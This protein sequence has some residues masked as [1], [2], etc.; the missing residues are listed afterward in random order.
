MRWSQSKWDEYIAN[1]KCFST[2]I[3]YLSGCLILRNT[4]FTWKTINQVFAL[5]KQPNRMLYYT[6]HSIHRNTQKRTTYWMPK[7]LNISVNSKISFIY[8]LQNVDLSFAKVLFH[9][10]FNSSPPLPSLNRLFFSFILTSF[11]QCFCHHFCQ[12][13]CISRKFWNKQAFTVYQ[14]KLNEQHHHYH[15]HR[16]FQQQKHAHIK[17]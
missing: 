15:H 4:S 2:K 9:T 1:T 11:M 16:Q 12:H 10:F 7:R 14:W 3:L 8:L 5:Q 17:P 6:Q 13:R